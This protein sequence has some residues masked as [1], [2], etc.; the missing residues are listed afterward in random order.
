[1]LLQREM[2]VGLVAMPVRTQKAE[3]WNVMLAR[4]VMAVDLAETAGRM[5]MA[6]EKID[7]M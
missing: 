7:R 3:R 6:A 1:M 5:Q 4:R 2:L